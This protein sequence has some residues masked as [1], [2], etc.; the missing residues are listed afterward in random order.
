LVLAGTITYTDVYTTG[1]NLHL[2]GAGDGV[3]AGSIRDGSYAAVSLSKAGAG[4]WTL[5]GTN[6]FTSPTTLTAGSLVINGTSRSA[7][8]VSGGTL[9][10]FGVISNNVT[11][12]G[13]C[14]APGDPVGIQTIYGNYL[15]SS[16]GT[17]SVQIRGP[18]AGSQYSRVSVRGGNANSVTLAGALQLVASPGLPTNTTFIVIEHDGNGAVSGTFAGLP[19]NSTF[20]AGGYTWR[21][22]YQAGDG[23][24]VGLTVVTGSAPSLSATLATGLF[25]VTWPGWAQ[26]FL[27]SSTTNLSPPVTWWPVSNGISSNDGQWVFSAPAS[28]GQTFFQLHWP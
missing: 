7:V 26:Q 16:G 27:L 19:N 14:H 28:A 13:G 3:V 23:N 25:K 18:A 10:G 1:R 21:V 8:T 4:R 11:V 22:N 2:A 5:A 6:S 17:L 24:D 15:L 20:S 9:G 12:A